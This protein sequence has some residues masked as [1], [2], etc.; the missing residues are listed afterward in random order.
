M[1][2]SKC[3]R[4]AVIFQRYSGLHLCKSH[5][6]AD[7]ETK[8]KRAVRQHRWIASGDIVAVA[9]S[10]GKGSSAVL[11]FLHSILSKRRDVRLM[12]ITIDEGIGK[13]QRL[14]QAEAVARMIGVDWVVASFRDEY[15]IT[16]EAGREDLLNRVAREHGV[17]KL[18]FGL[19]LDD[20]AE[21]VLLHVLQGDTKRL[22]M[23]DRPCPGMVPQIKPLMYVPECEVAL[24]ASLH[25]R[26]FDL[27]CSPH[28]SSAMQADVREL[29]NA[30][31]YRHPAT[32]NA[33]VNVGEALPAACGEA[34]NKVKMVYGG[35]LGP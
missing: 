34:P 13:L 9:L 29:L 15:G 30:Y 27:S 22:L 6:T 8:A 5:F 25:V 20:G 4:D 16:P 32:K 21:S 14:E 28:S 1:K 11:Y 26:G 7:V 35:G 2:C 23:Q 24:Y 17:T 12:A 10:G 3:N 33:L 31:T 19:N 18:A